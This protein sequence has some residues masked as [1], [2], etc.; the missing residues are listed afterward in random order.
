M[1]TT[2]KKSEIISKF[3]THDGDNGSSNVQIALLTE[4]INELTQHFA[5]HVSDHHSRRG[6]LK[7]VSRRKKLLDYL[8]RHDLASY[9]KL[10]GELGIRK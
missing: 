4:R 5:S 1:M 2:E 6:F 8:R 7:L 3:K 9:K 10:I